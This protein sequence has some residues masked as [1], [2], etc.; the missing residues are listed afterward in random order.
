MNVLILA[1]LIDLQ[2]SIDFSGYSLIFYD[3]LDLFIRSF[4]VSQEFI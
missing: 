2:P 3:A 1:P 4:L